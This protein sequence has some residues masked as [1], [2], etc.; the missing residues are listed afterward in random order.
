MGTLR[1]GAEEEERVGEVDDGKT[2]GAPVAGDE[3]PQ[4]LDGVAAAPEDKGL[5]G[6]DADDKGVGIHGWQV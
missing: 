1:V 6:V 4:G 5:T 2:P 3:L